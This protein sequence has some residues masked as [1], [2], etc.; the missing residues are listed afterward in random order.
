MRAVKEWKNQRL[1][2]VLL[3][4][5]CKHFSIQP[6]SLFYRWQKILFENVAS[7]FKLQNGTGERNREE[8]VKKLEEKLAHKD[9]VIAEIMFDYVKLKRMFTPNHEV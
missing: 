2:D 7:A 4:A 5:R 6:P 9:E 8:K 3:A 1:L